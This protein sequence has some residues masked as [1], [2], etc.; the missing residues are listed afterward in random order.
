[1]KRL[2]SALTV[3]LTALCLAGV[4]DLPGG[5][6]QA[7]AQTKVGFAGSVTWFGQVPIMVA[8]EKG[9]FKEQGIDVDFLTILNSSDR[10]AALT[11]GSVQFSNLGRLAVIAQM[12]QGNQS[13]YYLT[14]VDD[15]PGNEGCLGR[16]GIASFKD[17]KGKKVAANTSAEITMHGLLRANGMTITDIQ[18]LNLPPNEMAGALSKGDVD[19]ACVWQPLLD[20]MKKAVPEGKLLGLDTDTDTYQKYKSMGAPDI[21]IIS[22]KFVDEQPAVAQKLAAAMLKGADYTNSNPEDAAKAIAHYFKKTPEETLASIKS[23]QYFGTKDWQA[24]MARHE[25]QMQDLADW[26]F[27]NKKLSTKIADVTKWRSVNVLK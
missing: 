9:F 10:I 11:A 5:G 25:K 24:H 13:F 15:S 26:L 16:P 8:I 27:D 2:T 1:M 6:G 21:V 3:A 17:L 7:A 18:Y 22:K 14:N 4:P 20:G 12:A 23:F 19:A